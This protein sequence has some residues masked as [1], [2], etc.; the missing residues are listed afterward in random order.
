VANVERRAH[1][2]W[3]G[4]L[5]GGNGSLSK[6]DSGVLRDAAVTFASR[7]GSPEGKT[8]PEELIASAHATCCAIALSNT[9]AE[10]DAPPVRLKV[11]AVCILDDEQLKITTVDIEVRG[12]GYGLNDEEFQSAVQQAEQIFPVSN[13]LRNNVEI[14]VN[15]SLGQ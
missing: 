8:S 7:T 2:V 9:L 15:A 13:A 14:R 1:A 10:Q 6:E 3:E 4:D 5:M 11:D 12:Q